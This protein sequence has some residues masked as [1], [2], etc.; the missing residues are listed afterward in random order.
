MS[1]PNSARNITV[2]VTKPSPRNVTSIASAKRLNIT[3]RKNSIVEANSKLLSPNSAKGTGRRKSVKLSSLDTNIKRGHHTSSSKTVGTPTKEYMSKITMKIEDCVAEMKKGTTMIK[4]GK[5]GSSPKYRRF[6]LSESEQY[7]NW[8]S[9]GK[10]SSVTRIMIRDMRNII[11]GQETLRFKACSDHAD[12]ADVSFS[13]IFG[14]EDK[15]LD[16]VAGSKK[17]YYI[18]I[19]GLR[20]LMVRSKL[21]G[22]N[23]RKRKKNLEFKGI[24]NEQRYIVLE[25]FKRY[26]TVTDDMPRI[27]NRDLKNVCKDLGMDFSHD[28]FLELTQILDPKDTGYIEFEDFLY[29]CIE[30]I[31]SESSPFE[32]A[33]QAFKTLDVH[34]TGFIAKRELRSILMNAAP[35]L[36]ENEIDEIINEC[37]AFKGFI[38]YVDFVYKMYES[39]QL[40]VPP[41]ESLK[42]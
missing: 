40:P 24:T 9:E 41:R 18:Y 6:Y 36:N 30:E 16:L 34:N 42:L 33:L 11:E 23:L 17:D 12:K 31:L 8:T 2:S 13:I 7:L 29:N 20:Y 14:H 10:D 1:A 4:Y 21:G 39:S 35:M 25:V 19:E 15:S 32:I 22:S 38:P 26:D 37:P 28:E 5:P 3:P 27:Y